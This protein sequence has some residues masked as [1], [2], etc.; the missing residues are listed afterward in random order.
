MACRPQSVIS[1][2]IAYSQ[3]NFS[4]HKNTP[5]R[6]LPPEEPVLA[7]DIFLCCIFCHTEETKEAESLSAFLPLF[8]SC[9]GC[10]S[11]SLPS[12]LR[13][14]SSLAFFSFPVKS[15]TDIARASN[16]KK[17]IDTGPAVHPSNLVNSI[18]HNNN[19]QKIFHLKHICSPSGRKPGASA[20]FYLPVKYLTPAAKSG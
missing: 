12:S 16:E 4:I 17:Y 8:N 6:K 10:L 14:S 3:D 2:N 13:C 15:R 1:V 7:P 5:A 19:Q 9:Y 20:L 11:C 18:T